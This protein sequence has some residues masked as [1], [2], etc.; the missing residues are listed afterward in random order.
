MMITHYGLFWKERDVFWGRAGP[1]G[2]G[3]L[4]GRE[5]TP[6]ERRGAPTREERKAF[7]DYKDFIGLYCLYGGGALLYVGETGLD[8]RQSLFQRLKAHR[9]GP[10]AG[11]WDRFSWFGRERCGDADKT[12]VKEALSQLEAISIA[13]INPGFNKQSGTFAGATQVFQEPHEEAQG[14]IETKLER[15]T[16]LVQGLCGSKAKAK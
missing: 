9:K 1:N 11:R 3:Q 5:K 15:L 2:G 10:M 6:R 12:L 4:L 13:I 8:T 16:A 14:D 7:K